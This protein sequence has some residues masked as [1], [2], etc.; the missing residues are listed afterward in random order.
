MGL[1]SLNH[2]NHERRRLSGTRP[3]HTNDIQSLQKQWNRLSLNWR[4]HIET[5]LLNSLEQGQAQSHGLEATALLQALPLHHRSFPVPRSLLC[6]NKR[7]IVVA[8]G[9]RTALENIVR[10][11][12]CGRR[13]RIEAKA[14]VAF[15]AAVETAGAGEGVGNVKVELAPGGG[16]GA[17]WHVDFVGELTGLPD[18]GGGR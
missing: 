7:L 11:E 3:S 6:C 4:R 15:V 9:I 2:R 5:L 18:V 12:V 8:G 14:G 16:G 10:I 13:D 17:S 1:Q